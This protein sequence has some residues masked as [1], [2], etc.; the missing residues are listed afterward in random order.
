MGRD[1]FWFTGISQNPV[2]GRRQ[3][4]MIWKN[5][6]SKKILTRLLKSIIILLQFTSD[7]NSI[8][9]GEVIPNGFGRAV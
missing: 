9:E 2:A 7:D 1:G 5:Y 6:F 4:L 8:M 3:C